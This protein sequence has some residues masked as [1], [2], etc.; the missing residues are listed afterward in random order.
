MNN[1]AN[2]DADA[3]IAFLTRWKKDGPWVLTAIF[4]ERKG[5][6]ARTFRPDDEE[7]LRSWLTEHGKDNLYFHVNPVLRDL[8]K[9]AERTDVS[10]LAWLHVDIDPRAGEKLLSERK[11]AL[12]LLRDPP[13]GIPKPTA[14]VFSGG[15]FHGYWSLAEPVPIDGEEEKYEAAKLFNLQL[16]IAFGADHCHN[17]DRIMRLPGTVNWPNE[18]KKKKGRTPELAELVEWH[19]DRVYPIERFTK[20][21]MVQPA[22]DFDGPP[23]FQITGSTR[24]KNGVD[25]LPDT[26]SDR[27]KMLIVQGTDPDDPTKY[28]SRSEALFGVCCELVRAGLTDDTIY[29][30]VTDPDFG[31]SASVLDKGASKQRY[32]VRQITRAREAN[33]GFDTDDNGKPYKTLANLRRAIAKLGVRLEY[34]VFADRAIVH[35][36]DGF[37]PVLDDPAYVRMWL[38]I[39]E[40]YKLS[41]GKDKFY[42]VVDD[43]A[44]K[45]RRHPVCEYLATL[46]WDGKKR[47]DRFL[48]DYFGAPD[49]EYVRA[50]GPIVLIAAVRRVRH[51]GCKF[52]EMLVLES[53]QGTDKSTA[54]K[55]LA[56]CED[57]FS[58][59]LPL[60]VDTA[61]FIESVAG[62]WIIE[63]G[64]LKGMRKG[65][66][67]ALKSTLSRQRD[68]ARL[69][70]GRR[71]KELPRQCIIIGT[72]NSLKYL[73]DRT[74]NRRYW[75]VRV[76]K[77]AVKSLRRDRDQ[78]WAEAAY[79]EAQGESIRLDPRFWGSAAREQEKREVEDPWLP[80][81]SE[82]LGEYES[83]K[84]R[85]EDV[86]DIVGLQSGHRKQEHNDRLG[87]VMRKLGWEHDQLRWKGPQAYCYWKGDKKPMLYAHQCEGNRWTVSEQEPPF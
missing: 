11:R 31:I 73:R 26:V 10:S 50:V 59:D 70:W 71:V 60:N 86:W 56:V 6:T 36:L 17:V 63:A 78:L 22:G 28:T 87:D 53:D 41:F 80:L 47:L 48:I 27:T 5:I 30:V 61:K 81:L 7:A 32:A 9:K 14:I 72:T 21:P 25:D 58:D 40:R 85:T 15:G 19:D 45:T 1:P 42:A 82:L 76:G 83:G 54:L 12:R 3:A 75:P 77:V 55:V 23:K 16:E 8:D 74:G 37:G 65:E 51:P 2:Q 34:D 43:V 39:E 84:I 33:E 62:K 13:N 57:W 68:R 18:L 4:T 29:A 38:E 49:T 35:G 79:R 67:E 24:L 69:A 52:D 64:E 66:V 20:A 44:F 46:K